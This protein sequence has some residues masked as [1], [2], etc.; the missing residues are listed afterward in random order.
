MPINLAEAFVTFPPLLLPQNVAASGFTSR[1]DNDVITRI[2][3]N[4]MHFTTLDPLIDGN[5]FSI[6]ATW[7]K[8][9]RGKKPSLRRAE[10]LLRQ[11]L[12]MNDLLDAKESTVELLRATAM[13]HTLLEQDGDTQNP[14]RG[15]TLYLLGLSYSRLPLYFVNE[16]PDF[17]LELCIRENPATKVAKD[18]YRLYANNTYLDFTGSGGSSVPEDV[19]QKIERLY[20]KAYGR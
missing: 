19:Q 9:A 5:G 6:S 18:C 2:R 7:A 12:G 16:L 20:K 1:G 3:G 8:E 15:R 11:S 10:N 4:R 13:L 17:F 14:E